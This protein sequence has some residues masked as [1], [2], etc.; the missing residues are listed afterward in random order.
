MNPFSRQSAGKY[1]AAIQSRDEKPTSGKGSTECQASGCPLPGTY[2]ISN[3]A[4]LC[5]VHDSEDAQNWPE[6]T[7]RIL[8]RLRLWWLALNMSNA[9]AGE[10]IKQKT[11]DEVIA[12]GGPDDA[13]VRTQRD[14]AQKIR[15]FL[16]KECKGQR[17]APVQLTPV[18][19]LISKL[20]GGA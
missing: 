3:E 16:L 9:D 14:Y 6:Q 15:A 11:I 8:G 19:A 1:S 5:C 18:K 12:E 10:P 2:R 13:D 20:T 7:E 17:K 4:S